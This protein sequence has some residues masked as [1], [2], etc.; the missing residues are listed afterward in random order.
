VEHLLANYLI[1]V[2]ILSIEFW[3]GDLNTLDR[4]G[5]IEAQSAVSDTIPSIFLALGSGVTDGLF[6]ALILSSI[7]G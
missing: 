7:R 3:R 2:G 1:L 5:L 4:Y 6:G